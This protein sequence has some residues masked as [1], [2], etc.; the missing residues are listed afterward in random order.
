MLCALL[1]LCLNRDEVETTVQILRHIESSKL[2]RKT[3]GVAEDQLA[4]DVDFCIVVH[5]EIKRSTL[6]G[7]RNIETA[8]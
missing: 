5:F 8:Q 3:V 1:I 7:A 4:I 2:A 6:W